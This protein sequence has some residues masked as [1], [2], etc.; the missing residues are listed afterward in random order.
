MWD[1]RTPSGIFFALLGAILAA[2]GL[3]EPNLRAPLL[4][5]NINLW[6]GITM[7]VFGGILLW[8]ARRPS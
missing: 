6:S 7:L 2:E 1:L 3:I 5:V 4:E 8:L